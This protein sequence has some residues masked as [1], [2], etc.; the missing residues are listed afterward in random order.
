M[1]TVLIRIDGEPVT[2]DIGLRDSKFIGRS[3]G[4]VGEATIMILDRTREW[5]PGDLHTGQT[6]ELL[7]DGE[8]VW[9]GFVMNVGRQYAFDVDDTSNPMATPRYWVIKGVDRNILLQ[10]RV[11]FGQDDPLSQPKRFAAG[12]SDREAILWMHDNWLDTT[13]TGV[14]LDGGIEEIET[15]GPYE[16]FLLGSTGSPWGA[17]Y[18]DCSKI[19]GGVYFIGANDRRVHY[20]DSTAPDAPAILCDRPF[21]HGDAWGYRECIDWRESMEMANEAFVWGAG[22][23][24]AQP[25]FAHYENEGSIEAHGRWQ[26]ADQWVGANQTRTVRKRAE[27]YVDGS[28]SHQRGHS[29]EIPRVELTVYDRMLRAGMVA[30]FHH[31]Q[32]GNDEPL[33]IRQ[34]QY[35]FPTLGHVR[36][37]VTM[38]LDYDTPFGWTDPW[39]KSP[40]EE[41]VPIVGDP[42]DDTPIVAQGE[43]IDEFDREWYPTDEGWMESHWGTATNQSTWVGNSYG[44]AQYVDG[45]IGVKEG[46]EGA[47]DDQVHW[48]QEV[49]SDYDMVMPFG[50]LFRFEIVNPDAFYG[51]DLAFMLDTIDGRWVFA[52]GFGPVEWG[53]AGSHDF[54]SWTYI[55]KERVMPA[56]LGWQ[57]VRFVMDDD[58]LRIRAWMEEDSEPAGWDLDLSWD[59]YVSLSGHHADPSSIRLGI[60][61]YGG[62]GESGRYIHMDWI[63]RT[64][65]FT[66]GGSPASGVD[67]G[68]YGWTGRDDIYQTAW[69]YA[70]GSLEVWFQGVALRRGTDFWELDPEQGTFRIAPDAPGLASVDRSDDLTIRYDRVG[71]DRTNPAPIGGDIGEPG[72]GSSGH[73]YRPAKQQQLGWGTPF[74]G[75]NCRATASAMCL[76]RH[77]LGSYSSTRG[78]PRSTP[79]NI[80]Y[81]SGNRALVGGLLSR[82]IVRAWKVGWNQTLSYPGF[83]S[84]SY[85]RAA[86]R[87]GRGAEF[88]GIYGVLPASLR[89]TRTGFNGPHSIYVN[90][91]LPNGNYLVFDPLTNKS[92]VYTPQQ[93]LSYGQAFTGIPGAVSATYSRKTG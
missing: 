81:Y 86:I 60:A 38:T 29:E 65:E 74:D 34:V 19:T 15:P 27:S 44:G 82:D 89:F 32:F 21:L 85:F 72:G 47:D 28:P 1:T 13:D 14:D 49:L 63:R 25:V 68:V 2:A 4:G 26:W 22:R 56:L 17:I 46:I 57:R 48:Q 41:D 31:H 66:P 67:V 76:D 51:Y 61:G 83:H 24:S 45:D 88:A 5:A 75:T 20:R 36:L 6:L 18:E 10:R 73:P 50:C 33:P 80:R 12:T 40:W 79:P 78:S 62:G 35:T 53:I 70:P 77:S 52:Y 8:R 7:L 59:E 92:L 91:E 16:I 54:Q 64:D 9:D 43:T 30:E 71:S 84:W 23:G 93:L 3:N 90:E 37:D 58:G 87:E 39:G 69:S 11:I 42:G 55:Y